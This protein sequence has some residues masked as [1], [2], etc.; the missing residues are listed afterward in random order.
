MIYLTSDGHLWD[1]KFPAQPLF[2]NADM[3]DFALVNFFGRCYISPSDG[4]VGL[5]GEIVYVYD[6]TGISGF[7]AAAGGTPGTPLTAHVPITPVSGTIGIGTHLL[8]Y[9]FETASGFIT[10]PATPFVALD[11]FGA[12]NIEVDNLPVGPTG[13]VARWLIVTK[14]IP[15]RADLGVPFDV[16]TADFYPQY[17]VV[18]IDNNTDTTYSLTF[19]DE[20][21][22]ESADYLQTLLT[23]IP[24]GV[25]LLDYK[26]RMIIYGEFT[27]PS[28][29]R[30]S[31]P[32][33]PE[34]ISE[35]S[36]FF[37]TDPSDS[38]GVR[39]ATEFRNLLYAYK[40]QRGYVTQDNGGELSTWDVVNFEKSIGTEQYGIASI[41]DAKGASTEGF[42]IASRGAL[43]YFNGTVADPELSFKIRDLWKRINPANFYKMQLANDPINKRIYALVPLND[44]DE[45]NQV[46]V[47]RTT[48]SHIIV[49]DYRDGLDPFNIKWDVW[50][51]VNPPVSILIYNEFSASQEPVLVTRLTSNVSIVTLN[52]GIQG[53]D[54]SNPID[55][56][57]ILA[58]FRL[59][60]GISHYQRMRI[61]VKGPCR[62]S[63]TA[64]GKDDVTNFPLAELSISTPVPG[65]EYASLMNLVSEECNFKVQC[66]I[67]NARYKINMLQ[68][69]G[70][71]LWDERAR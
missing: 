10:R 67:L 56:Y 43:V 64:Y 68:L 44:L 3:E 39:S 1:E 15:F 53:N 18:R 42:L 12:G 24:A 14:A 11:Y 35:T 21:L 69:Q 50:K 49:G 48:C 7:R 59:S 4:R 65:R 34:T 13:T 25:G 47:T 45:N 52:I 51:F 57:F 9:A 6:G 17:L 62:L 27:N 41:L 30:G 19:Y 33:D 32:G 16:G 36:G 70:V 2:L 28:I 61:D 71:A 58:P 63:M 38:T 5:E 54:D 55:S 60:N 26:G 37:I 23:N 22:V 66:N 31:I 29:V 40:Q 46:I 20:N 8:S